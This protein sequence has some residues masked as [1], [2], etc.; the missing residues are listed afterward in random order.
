MAIVEMDPSIMANKIQKYPV[1]GSP[2]AYLQ[3]RI[4]YIGLDSNFC[5]WKGTL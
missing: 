2:W 3:H 1:Y 5:V 4:K